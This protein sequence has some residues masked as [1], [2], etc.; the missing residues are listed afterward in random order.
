MIRATII[1]LVLKYAA[2]YGV[3]PE[4]A[5]AVAHVE[6]RLPGQ[7]FRTG[8]VGGGKFYAP[9][10]IHK[11]FLKKWPE[12]P[13][14][15]LEHNIHVGVRALRGSSHRAV[16]RRYNKSFNEPYYQ[17]IMAAMRRYKQEVGRE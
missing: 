17:A 14:S 13:V 12:T 15:E 5:L 8:P 10:N 9:F 2:I 11:D 7:E 1:S 3:A 16:L 4:F 6:S